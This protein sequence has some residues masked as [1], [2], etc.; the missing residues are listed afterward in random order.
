MFCQNPKESIG[1]NSRHR[2]LQLGTESLNLGLL[3]VRLTNSACYTKKV[4]K[5]CL[6][7][8]WTPFRPDFMFS[9]LRMSLTMQEFGKENRK[10]EDHVSGRLKR[11]KGFIKDKLSWARRQ[12]DPGPFQGPSGVYVCLCAMMLW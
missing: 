4:Q 9:I 10:V 1:K 5:V 3:R 7:K 6:T 11:A 12:F 8:L 2:N